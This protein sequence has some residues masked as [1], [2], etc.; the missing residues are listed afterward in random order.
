MLGAA[1]DLLVGLLVTE[2][3]SR[4]WVDLSWS[5][6][7][8]VILGICARLEGVKSWAIFVAETSLTALLSIFNVCIQF[9]IPVF[10]LEMCRILSARKV[11]TFFISCDCTAAVWLRK[12]L[13]RSKQHSNRQQSAAPE[14]NHSARHRRLQK[15]VA[16]IHTKV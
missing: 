6:C 14:V 16:P 9:R 3:F 2:C 5:R 11:S 7:Y 15:T 1:V 4:A 10:P 12:G 13:C 8:L